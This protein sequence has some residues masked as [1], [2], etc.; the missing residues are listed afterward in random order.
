VGACASGQDSIDRAFAPVAMGSR[1][2]SAFGRTRLMPTSMAAAARC[3][4]IV[5]LN[6]SG[7]T[8]IRCRDG[9]VRVMAP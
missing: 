7:L 5:P 1:R 6:L 8:R 2:I 9:G 4:H 3:A